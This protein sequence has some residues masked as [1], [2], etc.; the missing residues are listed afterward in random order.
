[1]RAIDAE[2]I[3]RRR[4]VHVMEKGPTGSWSGQHIEAALGELRKA[5]EPGDHL[6]ELGTANVQ[7]TLAV[8]AL[9]RERL[10]APQW[11]P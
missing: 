5:M 1:M 11:R 9:L 10:P 7:A 2:A 4:V 6:K 3:E 8:Y